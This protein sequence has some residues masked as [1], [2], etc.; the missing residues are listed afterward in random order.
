MSACRQ[1]RESPLVGRWLLTGVSARWEDG[2][3][4]E[5]VLERSFEFHEDG[6]GRIMGCG[7]EDDINFTWAIERGYS[8]SGGY[9]RGQVSLSFEEEDVLYDFRI[10]EDERL[11]GRPGPVLEIMEEGENFSRTRRFS[12]AYMGG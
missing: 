1:E 7:D 10:S 5:P 3:D 12:K 9:F 11:F 4:L 8:G 2:A 6:S